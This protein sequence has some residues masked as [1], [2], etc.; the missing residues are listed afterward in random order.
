MRCQWHQLS[1]CPQS[2]L[3]YWILISFCCVRWAIK[4]F[5]AWPS[6]VQ[7]KIKIVFTS[8][9]SQAENTTCTIWLLSYIYLVHFSGRQLSAVE[10]EKSGVTQYNEWQFW[11]I[12]SFHCVLCC[13]DSESKLWMHVL[14]WITSDI[15]FCWVT[16]V[17]FE[18]FFRSF[19]AVLVLAFSTPSDRHFVHMLKCTKYS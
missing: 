15:N 12:R 2:S 1:H 14:S 6:Y 13:S 18:K 4:K 8:Y 5:L 17:S 19:C 10:V 3:V 11:L 7:N 9:S 16:S